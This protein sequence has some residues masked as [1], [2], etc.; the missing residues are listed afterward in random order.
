M[1]ISTGSI[2]IKVVFHGS[3]PALLLRLLESELPILSACQ[4]DLHRDG[5]SDI[6]L[7][8]TFDCHV[9]LEVWGHGSI[10]HLPDRRIEFSQIQDTSNMYCQSWQSRFWEVVLVQ[11]NH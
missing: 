8:V 7:I 3:L 10:I 4:M 9:I 11:T 6:H 5:L 1:L 2:A